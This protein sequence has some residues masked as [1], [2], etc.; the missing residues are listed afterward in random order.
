MIWFLFFEIKVYFNSCNIALLHYLNQKIL[1]N[2]R[3]KK[4]Y[5]MIG[6]QGDSAVILSDDEFKSFVW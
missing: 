2:M 5:F 3:I 1:Q 4:V 6:Q